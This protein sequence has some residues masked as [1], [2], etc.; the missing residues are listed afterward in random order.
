MEKTIAPNVLK[1][2]AGNGMILKNLRLKKQTY[3]VT[4]VKNAVLLLN[5][6]DAN[7]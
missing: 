1:Y 6:N 3:I 2:P 7:V 4:A 5:V